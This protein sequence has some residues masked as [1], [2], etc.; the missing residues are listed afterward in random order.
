MFGS[1]EINM[2]KIIFLGI[3]IIVLAAVMLSSIYMI[4]PLKIVLIFILVILL[5]LIIW[6]ACEPFSE[7]SF[8]LGKNIPGSVRG[9]TIDAIASSMPEFFTVMFFLI[10]FDTYESGIA[11]CAGSAI[12]NMMVIPAVCVFFVYN[13]RK[14]KGL[15]PWLE[16]ER[17]VIFRDGSYF[18]ISEFLLILFLGTEELT[19][20]M[21]LILLLMYA[22]YIFWLWLDVKKHRT[23]IIPVEKMRINIFLNTFRKVI[24]GKNYSALKKIWPDFESSDDAEYYEESPVG[25]WKRFREHI[26]HIDSEY[27]KKQ[28]YCRPIIKGQGKLG[29]SVDYL[30]SKRPGMFRLN[31]VKNADDK[32][33]IK[34]VVLY[35]HTKKLAWVTIFVM[36]LIVA[37]ACYWLTWSCKTLS[38][39][40]NIAP[41]FVAVIIAAAATSVPDTFLSMLSAKKGDDSGSI[42]NA[43]GSNIFDV[44]IGLG[45]PLLI[46]TI[47]KG[48]VIIGGPGIQE[49]RLL[50]F[51]LSFITLGLFAYKLNLTRTKAIV[52]LF[53]YFA[54]MAT[55][56]FQGWLGFNF[57]D[58][59]GLLGL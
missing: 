32:W 52:L 3:F 31:I 33:I 16:V 55:M 47:I 25:F 56:L 44:N 50:L 4:G 54:F 12:Y 17:E 39:E 21:A 23:E 19:W 59:P 15:N 49:V 43:F 41:F 14:K 6:W 5:S 58:V 35:E 8:F 18:L 2:N 22:L 34:S 51:V 37:F 27:G 53:L 9:A 42:S 20:W 11:T 30:N 48:P 45:L 29:Y 10:L 28:K 38:I 36:G 46:W 57:M 40:M 1:E 13:I 26:L 7:A 24:F